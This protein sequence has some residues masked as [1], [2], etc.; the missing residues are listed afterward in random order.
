MRCAT[1]ALKQSFG[2]F[3][4]AIV[5]AFAQVAQAATPQDAIVGTWLTEDGG[6][7]VD[8]VAGKAADGSAVYSGKVSWLKDPTRDGKPL[9]DA[10]NADVALRNRPILGLEILSGF[11]AAGAGAWTGGTLYSPRR[12]ESFPADLSLQP[13]GSLE[14]KVKAGFMTKTVRWTRSGAT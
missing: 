6:S 4:V 13:D 3:A 11:K 2:G 9:V 7:K 1:S 12:G 5:M 10:S 8:V 14:L